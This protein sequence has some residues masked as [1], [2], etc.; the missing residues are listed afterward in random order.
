[1][2]MIFILTQSSFLFSKMFPTT[3]FKEIECP[4]NCKS[5][6]HFKHSESNSKTKDQGPPLKKPKQTTETKK[7]IN[8]PPKKLQKLSIKPDIHS[9]IDMKSRQKALDLFHAQFLRIYK[10]ARTRMNIQI[11]YLSHNILKI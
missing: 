5:H 2:N 3:R 4:F 9:K 11:F 8:S 1:M 10:N 7:E 6:C